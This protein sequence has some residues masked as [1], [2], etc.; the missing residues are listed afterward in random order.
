MSVKS[1]R[2]VRASFERLAWQ[3]VAEIGAA[4]SV[5]AA[6]VA[7]EM[8]QRLSRLVHRLL[9]SRELARR[10]LRAD[11]AVW[12]D[13]PAETLEEVR[14]EAVERWG[15][16]VVELERRQQ[17]TDSALEC[18]RNYTYACTRSGGVARALEEAGLCGEDPAA[19]G[20]CAVVS[21]LLA[22]REDSG[23]ER[24]PRRAVRLLAERGRLLAAAN[25]GLTAANR[26]LAAANRELAAMNR[27]LAAMNRELTAAGLRPAAA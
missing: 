26:K 6:P 27:E 2:H 15:G 23:P 8:L 7:D 1:E 18:I 25:R 4:L 11:P 9:R 5:S 14:R 24:G 21:D 16:D 12:S 19:A 17:E 22:R 10:R 20:V 3:E 13:L